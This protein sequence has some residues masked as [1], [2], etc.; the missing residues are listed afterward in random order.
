MRRTALVAVALLAALGM[1]T[2][3]GWYVWMPS[4]RPSLR[5][6]EAYGIDVSW[7]QGIV[8]WKRVA[9]DGIDFAYVKATEG[10]DHLD[11]RYVENWTGARLAGIP[12]GAYHFFTLCRSGEEQAAN[13]LRAYVG[14]SELAPAVDL[15]I[16][17]NCSGRPG[18][19]SVRRELATFLRLVEETSGKPTVLY[20]G[21]DWQR[22]YP[23]EED[24]RPRWLRR[25]LRRPAGDWEVWQVQ[26]RAKVDGIHGPVDFDVRR[27]R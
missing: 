27:L 8:D 14:D 19:E 20:I 15:E 25:V 2:A 17:G 7:H 18:R 9:D 24:G 11:P 22:R 1:L 12:R 5:A 10:G 3:A 23:V 4:Y 26:G 6:G 21:E 13:F 16:A